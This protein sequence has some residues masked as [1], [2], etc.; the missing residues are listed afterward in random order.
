MDIFKRSQNSISRRDFINGVLVTAG[1][2]MLASACGRHLLKSNSPAQQLTQKPNFDPRGSYG[3]NQ[4]SA[5]NIAH[6][7]RDQRLNFGSDSVKVLESPQDSIEGSFPIYED[8]SVVDVVILGAGMS[9]ISSAYF[10]KKQNPNLKILFLDANAYP[11]GNAQSD[12]KDL[13]IVGSAA[14]AYGTQPA[15]DYLKEIYKETGV[16]W[17][18]HIV[19]DPFYCYYYDEHSPHVLPGTKT[20]KRD[21]YGEGLKDLPYPKELLRDLEIAKQDLISWYNLEEGITDPPDE[22]HPQFDYLST[23]S[24]QDYLVKIKK[25]HPGVADFFTP[26]ISSA[27]AG[28]AATINAHSA[29]GTVACEYF[30]RFAYPGGNAAI[31]KKFMYWLITG[32]KQDPDAVELSIDFL[33]SANPTLRFQQNSIAMRVDQN[34]DRS[35]VVYF[36]NGKF[37]RVHSRSVVIATQAHSSQ[38]LVRHLVDSSRQQAHRDITLAP[39]LVAN[40]ALRSSSMIRELN[41]GY[42][43][44]WWG[45]TYWSDFINA[46]WASKHPDPNRGAMLTVYG[47]NELPPEAMPGERFK[48]LTTPFSEYERSLKTDFTRIFQGTGFDFDRDVSAIH[49]YRW[50]HGMVYPK[51]NFIFGA[52]SRPNTPRQESSRHQVR[53]PLGSIY[54]AGQDVEGTPSI[55]SAIGS[56]FRVSQEISLRL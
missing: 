34:S 35:S 13:P 12:A 52:D 45:G 10:L 42:N 49:L 15:G 36:R 33:E 17:E 37:Y 29:I 27:L 48:L 11:G 8:P 9:G 46:D 47:G 30:P 31:A 56:G 3:G 40:V 54:F 1:S 4:P 14:A 24:Y 32:K 21:V 22:S 43:Q 7:L 19:K 2:G 28:S 44:F 51:V 5:F 41:L 25:L 38:H 23:M 18:Q 50:G 16:D 6:W 20:W 53:K 55:E 39:V 26:Y